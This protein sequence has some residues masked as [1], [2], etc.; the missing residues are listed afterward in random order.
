MLN[1]APQVGLFPLELEAGA[2][3]LPSVVEAHPRPYP[4]WSIYTDGNGFKWLYF[5]EH[6]LDDFHVERASGNAETETF[7]SPRNEH[8]QLKPGMVSEFIEEMKHC[9]H[10]DVALFAIKISPAAG[11]Y[12]VIDA[13]DCDFMKYVV[14]KIRMSTVFYNVKITLP[15]ET[16]AYRRIMD[17]IRNYL[18]PE[19]GQIETN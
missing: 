7:K 11:E 4:V 12:F 6:A 10:Q 17:R 13:M 19:E 2:A 5:T 16:D 15:E 14:P 8:L 9:K 3:G 18:P 1:T